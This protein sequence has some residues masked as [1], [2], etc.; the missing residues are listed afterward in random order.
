MIN[1]IIKVLLSFA[2]SEVAK[3]L[4][5]EAAKKVVQSTDNKIDDAMLEAFLDVAVASDGNKLDK[6]F[7]D[8]IMKRLK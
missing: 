1:F 8:A 3:E 6:Y 2:K 4:S 5:I 7:K